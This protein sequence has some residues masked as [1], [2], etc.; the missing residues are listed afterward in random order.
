[1]LTKFPPPTAYMLDLLMECHEKE[2][3]QWEPADAGST[4]NPGG[5]LSRGLLE[6]RPYINSKG[7]RIMALFVTDLGREYLNNLK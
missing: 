4:H 2:I 7:K 5:L 1:M 6:L 3:M